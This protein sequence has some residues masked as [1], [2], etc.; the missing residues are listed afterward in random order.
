LATFVLC[1]S[2]FGFVAA[3]RDWIATP[4]GLKHPDCVKEVPSGSVATKFRDGS[5]S[6]ETPNGEIITMPPCAHGS[7]TKKPEDSGWIVYGNFEGTNFNIFNGTWKVPRAP[8]NTGDGQTIFFFTGLEDSGGDEIIQPVI[9]FGPSEAGGGAYW[10][11]A[12]WWVTSGGQALYSTLTNCNTGDNIFGY[13][14]MQEQGTWDIGTVINGGAHTV[15]TVNN[16]AQQTF[17]SVTLEA[18]NIQDCQDY[19]ADG[20]ITFKSLVLY[21]SNSQVSPTW[22]PDVEYTSCNE[23]VISSGPSTVTI[24]Y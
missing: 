2:V 9:Q 3:T 4:K 11:A 14:I 24:T 12:S 18:Y 7:V 5:I 17:A 6:I 19:P 13:M 22:S 16:V 23:Q 10:A 15:L 20:K 1:L 8:T 21:D